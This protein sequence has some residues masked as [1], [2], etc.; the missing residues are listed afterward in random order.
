MPFKHTAEFK[1]QPKRQVLL[2]KFVGHLPLYRQEAIFRSGGL[3]PQVIGSIS[4][5]GWHTYQSRF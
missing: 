3:T 2:A 5:K 4:G 1:R